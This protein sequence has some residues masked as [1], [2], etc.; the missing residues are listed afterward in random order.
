MGHVYLEMFRHAPSRKILQFLM[1]RIGRIYPLHA[2]ILFACGAVALFLLWSGLKEPDPERFG[3]SCFIQSLALVQAW[4]L[5]DHACFNV[6]AWSISAEWLA[7]LAFP[8]VALVFL[9]LRS[10]V[11]GALGA[12]ASI[13]IMIAV[14]LA[15]GF[16][17]PLHAVTGAGAM[18]RMVGSFVAGCFL[19]A[20]Y[21]SGAWSG[22]A[23]PMLALLALAGIL[24]A[25]FLDAPLVT[26]PFLT[27]LVIALAY[28]RGVVAGV[29]SSRPLMFMGDISYGLYLSH[30]PVWDAFVR[31][32]GKGARLSPDSIWTGVAEI[33]LLVTVMLLV[34]V[35]VHHAIE[36]PGRRWFRNLAGRRP[37]LLGA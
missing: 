27:L 19:Y 28:E 23:W 32:Q 31:Y 16:E 25:A 29:L 33:G 8:L 21:R 37:S 13:A 14:L 6:V 9:P 2:T 5:V 36:I 26:I 24:A 20:I 17:K 10:P 22:V 1:L 12:I 35:A 11:I 15:L 3:V 34:A 30:W 18:T 7:Y 4:G